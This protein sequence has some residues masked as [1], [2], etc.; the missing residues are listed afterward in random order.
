M[1]DK[2]SLL[3][4]FLYYWVNL[5][6]LLHRQVSPVPRTIHSPLFAVVYENF[7]FPAQLTCY[8]G[9]GARNMRPTRAHFDFL[10]FESTLRTLRA[11]STDEIL[12]S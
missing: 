5:L 10:Q 7:S 11:Y 3:F 1:V 2:N 9:F 6:S 12:L 4:T 8:D